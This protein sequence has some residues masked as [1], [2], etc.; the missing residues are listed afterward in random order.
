VF[1]GFSTQYDIR[2]AQ[3]QYQSALAR[4]EVTKQQVIQQV[5]TAYYTLRT[6][7]DRVRTTRDLLASATQSEV[8]ARERYKEGV[9]S[10]VDLLIAQSALAS[11][12]AESANARWGWRSALAQLAHDVGILNARG[13]TTFSQLTPA[14]DVR[15]DR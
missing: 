7:T 15:P 3:E 9:G 12:R 2:A 4:A 11:A 8:V 13:D 1:T 5:F 14:P 10:I 6:S